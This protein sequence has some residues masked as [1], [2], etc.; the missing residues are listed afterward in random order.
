MQDIEEQTASFYVDEVTRVFNDKKPINLTKAEAYWKGLDVC[1]LW[2]DAERRT[3][4][5]GKYS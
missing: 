1:D 5:R 2:S 4:Y 3:Y